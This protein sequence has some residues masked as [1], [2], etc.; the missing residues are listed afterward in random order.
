M[1]ATATTT[2]RRHRSTSTIALSDHTVANHLTTIFNKTGTSN[3]AAAAV[4]AVQ[5]GLAESKPIE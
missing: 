3:R 5:H 2:N 1:T 4:F